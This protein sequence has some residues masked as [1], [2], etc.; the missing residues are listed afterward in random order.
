MTEPRGLPT[1]A[2]KA[3]AVRAMFDKISP[4][5]DLVNR[6]MTFGMDVGWRRRAITSLGLPPGSLVF[7][8]ACGTGDFCRELEARRYR[9]VG[10]D[11]SFGMLSQA[12]TDAPLV[13]ADTLALPLSS[14]AG[15]GITCGF[16]LRKVTDLDRL[17]YELARML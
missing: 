1:G 4:R 11:V 3:R 10:F 9:A 13:Q 15:V 8:V 12:K 14:G 2:E 17:F 16:A 7:D 6:V 5:Y